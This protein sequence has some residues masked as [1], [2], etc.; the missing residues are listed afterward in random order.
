MVSKKYTQRIERG[1]LN[2]RTRC[3]RLTRKTICF[4]KS[5]DIHDK[6]I[7]T[8]IERIAFN[9]HICK[10]EVRPLCNRSILDFHSLHLHV[11]HTEVLQYLF[12]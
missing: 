10:M 11:P 9:T 6:V 1:N 5:L 7:G 4:S 3:K 12:I 2:L 8:L